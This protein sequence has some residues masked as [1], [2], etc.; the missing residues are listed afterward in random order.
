MTAPFKPGFGLRFDQFHERAGLEAVDAAFVTFLAARDPA[1]ARRLVEAR[2]HAT[3]LSGRGATAPAA[4]NRREEATLLFALAPPFEAFI[5]QLFGIDEALEALRERQA[6]LEPLVWAKWKFVKRQALLTIAPESLQDVDPA[7]AAAELGPSFGFGADGTFDELAFARRLQALGAGRK[8]RR[9]DPPPDPAVEPLLEQ[10][11]RY[12]AWAAGT[13]AGRRHHRVPGR[14]ATIFRLPQPVVAEALIDDL[15]TVAPAQAPEVAAR[16]RDEPAGRERLGAAGRAPFDLTDRGPSLALANDEVHYCLYCHE[17]EGDT[18]SRGIVAAPDRAPAAVGPGAPQPL[19]FV[20]SVHD[21]VLAGCPLEQRISEFQ[22]LKAHQLPVAALAVIA[23]DNP[24]VA[25][26]GHRICNDCMKACVFQTQTP[27]DTPAAESRTL[28]DVLEL[29]WGVEIYSLLTRWNP[30]KFQRWLPEPDS[31]YEVLVV[32]LGPAGYTLAHHLLNAGHRVLAVDAL[33]IEPLPPFLVVADP[34]PV[35]DI[36]LLEQPL[37]DRIA[38][39]FGGVAEYGITVRWDKNNLTLIRLLLE[40]RRQF[41]HVG[42]TRFGSQ[43]GT[44]EAFAAGFDHIALCLGAGSPRTLAIENGLADGVRT[45]SDFLMALQLTG[46][47]RAE[48][49]AN[50]Q[51]R[52][53]VVVVGGGLTAVDT[54]T[55]SLAYYATQVEKFLVR[56]DALEAAG[57]VPAWQE[58]ANGQDR[59]IALEFIEHARALRAERARADAAGETAR[60]L[61]LLQSWGGATIVYRRRLIDSPAYRLSH[62]ELQ[63]ALGEGIRFVELRAPRRFEVDAA[64]AVAAVELAAVDPAATRGRP[65]RVDADRVVRL[66]ART[67]FVAAGTAPNTVLADEEPDSYRRATGQRGF[68]TRDHDGHPVAVADGD[69]KPS[70]VEVFVHRAPDG[71]LVSA[72]GDLHPSYAGNVV[73]A[74]ASARQA[75]VVIDAALRRR[76]P[77]GRNAAATLGPGLAATVRAVRPLARRVHEIVVAAPLAARRFAP[78]SFYRLQNIERLG[79]QPAMEGLAL[80]GASV[81]RDAGTVSLIVLEIGVSSRLS[82]AL[83]PGQPVIL[84]G[85]V[86]KP[87]EIRGGET[88]LLVGGG[89]GNA[90]LFSIGA[91]FR[92]Q[93]SRVL[94]IAGYRDQADLFLAEAIESAAD[95]VIWCCESTPAI[96]PRRPQDRTVLGTVVDGLRDWV[97]ESLTQGPAAVAAASGS[98]VAG[99]QVDP[100]AVCRVIVIGSDRMMSAVAQAHADWLGQHLGT[101]HIALASVNSPMQCMMKGVC[102]QCVQRLR[103]PSTGAER[104]VFTCAAQDQPLAEIDFACLAARLQQNELQEKV[105]FQWLESG[106]ASC[107]D[108]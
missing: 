58:S 97:S 24:M 76:P 5:A 60:V 18:C 87:T 79:G 52:L 30:M 26:T 74:M 4:E 56:H 72:L 95:A 8:R 96:E 36:A 61:D 44:R 7:A 14:E 67:V 11:R 54:A 81:D 75:A 57:V 107:E 45:A 22:W 48:S 78:G 55:E 33:K 90:V 51:V 13:S 28:R 77:A 106:S 85:P 68:V 83:R 63:R 21:V 3:N 92:D 93:G 34:D 59:V 25:G 104:H 70:A 102:G 108:R 65:S 43:L 12:A 31:G 98:R 50:L 91:A 103:D 62:E 42:G 16:C 47:A 66:A 46:A 99:C 84:M 89:L 101:G 40:R 41:R 64:G 94:Y 71:R 39:G 53:P 86:G 38:G 88:V 15:G 100:A 49:L 2:A 69:P 17:T 82:R 80:T 23:I 37:S 20:R 10:A 9:G 73:K 6:A 27:V 35:R 105:T 29:P 1:L 32:G 19:R